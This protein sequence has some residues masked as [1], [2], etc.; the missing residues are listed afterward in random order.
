MK[1]YGVAILAACFL[2]GQLLGEILGNLLGID[3]NV[4]G[5]GFA[6]LLLILISSFMTKKGWLDDT[7]E[8]GVAFWGAMYLPVVIAMSATQNVKAAL[9][10][11]WTAVL[12]GIIGTGVSFLII[13]FIAKL[14]KRK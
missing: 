13:P 7:S 4:G 1:I 6:M 2:I 14:N 10:G 8:K 3:G 12:I 9:S 5:V 11:G